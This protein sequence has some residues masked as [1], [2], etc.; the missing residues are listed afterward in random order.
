M[1][2]GRPAPGYSSGDNRV[3]W[4]LRTQ[5]R[6]CRHAG[7]RSGR[8]SR[9]VPSRGQAHVTTM[10]TTGW[11]S[12]C[13]E[14][15][16]RARDS[17]EPVA[18][19]GLGD[20]TTLGQ[21]GQ[22]ARHG[23]SGQTGRR[24]DLAGGQAAAQ[25]TGPPAPRL[26]SAP[27]AC[28]MTRRWPQTPSAAARAAA[29]PR[30]PS[31]TVAWRPASRGAP[32]ADPPNSLGDRA[33]PAR[34]AACRSRPTTRQG[35]LECRGGCDRSLG[36]A[37]RSGGQRRERWRPPRRPDSCVR[38]AVTGAT[39]ISAETCTS[40]NAS[41]PVSRAESAR[42]LCKAGPRRASRARPRGFRARCWRHR[43]ARVA[44]PPRMPFC[45]P[46][47]PLSPASMLADRGRG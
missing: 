5:T 1:P 16:Q 26:G 32:A 11:G 8:R 31:A 28:A 29:C 19:V 42:C 14:Q 22:S 33:P 9:P 15:A 20:L 41:L 35:A 13:R 17:E 12:P 24:R 2:V 45:A 37:P 25:S 18:A 6:R 3:V 43:R 21:P 34:R 44:R 10:A 46:P 40:P 30:S 47:V 38:D 4:R 36:S 39:A 27:P 7:P 23:R